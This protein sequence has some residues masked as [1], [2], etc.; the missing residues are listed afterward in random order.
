MIDLHAHLLPGVDDG[1]ADERGAL[2]LADRA[3]R[4]G[5][6]AMAATPHIDHRHGVEP[7]AL[8]ERA[9]TLQ[10]ALADEGIPL[11]VLQGGEITTARLYELDVDEL[12]DL[13]LGGGRH[14]LLECPF[15][16]TSGMADA[17]FR[18]QA[19]GFDV[20][21]AHPERSAEFIG[22]LPALAALVERGAATQITASS[23]DGA[24]GRPVQTAALEMLAA[25][26]V[27]VVASDAHD[28]ER[29]PPELRAS[30]ERAARWFKGLGERADYWVQEAPGAIVAAERVPPPPVIKRRRSQTLARALSGRR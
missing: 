11:R 22:R 24:F 15:G 12:R 26:L 16:R 21:L 6:T 18:A 5:I 17:V 8:R 23:L 25:G 7:A 3:V 27:H 4:S 28:A 2:A 29:R 9:A 10:Q 1:P 13:T 14:L 19:L 30:L 20:L